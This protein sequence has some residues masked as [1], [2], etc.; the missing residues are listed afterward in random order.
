MKDSGLLLCVIC[1][2]LLMTGCSFWLDGSYHSVKPHRQESA[3]LEDT[4]TVCRTHR[5]VRNAL[6]ELV[7][8]GAVK[9]VIYVEDIPQEE[10]DACMSD[11]IHYATKVNPIGAYA[12]ESIDY[13]VGTSAAVPAV[14]VD[15]AY[16]HNRSEI[17]LIKQ[18]ENMDEV[19]DVITGALDNCSAG[20]VLYVERY[21]STDIV[22]LIEDYVDENPALCMEMPQVAV[23][24]YPETGTQRVIELSFTYQTSRETL[25]SMQ[26]AV[27]DVFTSAELYVRGDAENREKYAQLYA[28]LMERYNYTIET[29]I[30]PTYSLLRYGVGDSK[31]FAVVYAQMCRNAGLDC[32]A[33]AGTKAGEPWYWNVIRE[34][35]VYYHIDL[36][37]CDRMGQFQTRT[38]E[39]ISGYVWDYSVYPMNGPKQEPA[40]TTDAM[41]TTDATD[42][43]TTAPTEPSQS[44]EPSE[45][46]ESPEDQTDSTIPPETTDVT[47][48]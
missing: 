8:N 41:D 7:E 37:E 38:G 40:D 30:T 22:Q 12:V 45:P 17:L 18:T 39:E 34:D 21:T 20:V 3:A 4:Q 36:L 26:E 5:E 23:L 27:A 25:R 31:A 19:R 16:I 32:Q 47:E 11:A 13:E 15:I 29:S 9:G 14:A 35:D 10:M 42:T 43:A 2:C 44:S 1:L 33:I 46:G 28:F 24:F 6:V 48:P